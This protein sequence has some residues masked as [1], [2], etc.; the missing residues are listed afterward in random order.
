MPAIAADC[1]IAPNATIIGD[2]TIGA[3]ASVWFGCVLRG[4]EEAIR[5]GPGTNIQDLTLVH[6]S[7]GV[8]PTIIG[9][10]VTVGH[11]A[12]IHGCTIE[13]GA[14]IGMGAIVLDQAVVGREAIVA[15]G[16]VVSP[17]KH[18]KAGELWA[19]VPAKCIGPATEKHVEM[20]RTIPGRYAAKGQAYRGLIEPS[21]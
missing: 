4:D 11:N 10:N 16:A 17:G 1:F 5:I 3:G 2:V 9:A 13:D 7:G 6:T 12:I 8:S 19:G 15:A 20:A 14:L 18:V 21:R